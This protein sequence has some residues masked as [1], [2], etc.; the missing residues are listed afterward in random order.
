[1]SVPAA[2]KVVRGSDLAVVGALIKNEFTT[3]QDLLVSGTNIKTVNNTPILGSGDVTIVGEQGPTGPQGPIGPKGNKGDK[4]DSGYTGAAGELQVVNDLDSGGATAA[5]SAEMGRELGKVTV[6]SS[7]TYS[8]SN[9]DLPVYKNGYQL[10][11]IADTTIGVN[12][13]SVVTAPSTGSKTLIVPVEGA[14]QISVSIYSTSSQYGSCFTDDNGKVLMAIYRPSSISNPMTVYVP[15]GATKFYWNLSSSSSSFTCT[16]IYKNALNQISSN[17]ENIESLDKKIFGGK[18][19]Y[20]LRNIPGMS[21]VE[22]LERGYTRAIDVKN[23][24]IDNASRV[25]SNEKVGYIIPIPS[26]AVSMN[27][28]LDY[29]TTGVYGIGFLDSERTIIGSYYRPSSSEPAQYS[30]NIPSGATSIY[31]CVS[32]KMG[33]WGDPRVEFIFDNIK[34]DSNYINDGFV[35]TEKIADGAVTS[36]KIAEG[37]IAGSLSAPANTYY[38]YNRLDPSAIK[39]GYINKNT[40]AFVSLAAGSSTDVH[41]TDYIPV[42]GKS[43]KC[44]CER[45]IGNDSGHGVYDANKTFLRATTASYTYQDGDAYVRFTISNTLNQFW[46]L[47]DTVTISGGFSPTYKVQ[48][49]ETFDIPLLLP[50][51]NVPEYLPALTATGAGR[52]VRNISSIAAGN[53]YVTPGAPN[54]LKR[55]GT[56]TLDAK[57]GTV[58]DLK[59]GFGA[60]NNT[61]TYVN[62]SNSSI[63][64][65]KGNGT[66]DY[67]VSHGLTISTFIRVSFTMEWEKVTVS[68]ATLSGAFHTTYT[69]PTMPESYGRGYVTT[70]SST[71]LTDV[72]L[73]WY[74]QALTSPIWFIGD[75]MMSMYEARWPYQI[76]T[77]FGKSDFLVDALAGGTSEDLFPDLQIL[78]GLGTPRYLVWGLGGNDSS[79]KWKNIAYQVEML[80][81]ERG[82]T[83]IYNHIPW[84]VDIED[85]SKAA[86]NTYVKNS[87]YR[88]MDTYAAV[89]SNDSGAWYEGYC[90]D[91]VHPTVLGAKAMAAKILTDIPELK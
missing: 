50:K 28:T 34:W 25:S 58:G 37:A 46:I 48:N 57:F 85:G 52:V 87:G 9:N 69:Y 61:G 39:H 73:E 86:Q 16:V 67:T 59:V 72:Q 55:R 60:D 36:E 42:N 53:K 43:M 10:K 77:L 78:L 6:G 33:F 23:I 17:K 45:G 64:I 80:C 70:G 29:S 76:H 38:S 49:I 71:T 44:Y 81:R 82:I 74:S 54:Y 88:Y 35:S 40:G 32:H 5:L 11:V 51:E 66:V 90:A 3:K 1:M 24:T 15:Y 47:E 68:V 91:G 14:Y 30:G 56:V 20:R 63:S 31:W 12:I 89:S 18:T 83:L 26:G 79:W 27:A 21:D 65:C 8:A 19:V 4:G 2:D 13:D 84:R 7:I 41:A 75:S 62:I 22:I